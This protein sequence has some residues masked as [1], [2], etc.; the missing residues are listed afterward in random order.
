MAVTHPKTMVP[1]GRSETSGKFLRTGMHLLRL[2]M[3]E[4]RVS[5]A[6]YRRVERMLVVG[7]FSLCDRFSSQSC[8]QP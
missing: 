5:R 7:I 2:T 3:R 1:A 4:G 8:I 6:P